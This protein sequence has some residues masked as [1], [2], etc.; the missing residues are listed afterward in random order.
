MTEER[1]ESTNQEGGGEAPL[2][3]EGETRFVEEDFLVPFLVLRSRA[4]R[5]TMFAAGVALLAVS[6]MLSGRQPWLAGFGGAVGVMFWFLGMWHSVGPRFF[7]RQHVHGMT[8]A[9]FPVR[10]RFDEEGM[11]ISGSWGTSLYR[12]RG[13]HSFTELRSCILV[14][15]GPVFRMVVPKRAF[16]AED[17]RVVLE[18]LRTRVTPRGTSSD[19]PRRLVWRYVALWVGIVLLALI[20]AGV[21]DIGGR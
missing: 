13:M 20:A 12:Y 5:Y 14:Q 18:L 10:F 4:N 6:V 7:A 11:T 17:R 15:T 1:S 9:E 16:S 21:I 3:V 19:S 2:C 8:E